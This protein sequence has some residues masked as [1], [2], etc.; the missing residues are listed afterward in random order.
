VRSSLAYT[1]NGKLLDLYM[2]WNGNY[3]TGGVGITEIAT[4]D[5]SEA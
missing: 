4:S 2:V 3:A 5:W 1:T